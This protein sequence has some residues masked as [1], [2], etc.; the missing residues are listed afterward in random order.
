MAGT[1]LGKAWVQIVPS[2]DGISGS[3]K[4][5]LDPEAAAAGESAGSKISGALKKTMAAG[6]AAVGAATDATGALVKKSVE[7]FAEYEQLAGGVEKIFDQAN[8]SKIMAD[9]DSAYKDLNMSA[10]QYLTSINQTG[11]AFAQ[12]M[13]DQKGYDIART[14]MKAIA[15]YSSGTGRNLDELNEKYALITRS[16]SS[17][18]SIADQFSGILP[19]T[20]KD[21]LEQAKAAGILSD[22]YSSLT[23]VPIAEY[24]EAV[25]KM[26][27]KGVTDMGLYGNTAKEST[28]TISG[29]LAMTKSAWENLVAGFANPD[30]DVG[31]LVQQL[32]ESIMGS[33]DEAGNHVKGL[34]DNIVPAIMQAFSGLGTAMNTILPQMMSQIPAL[35]QNIG[36][37]LIQSGGQL[38]ASLA[39][40][41]MTALPQLVEVVTG[42][43]GTLADSIKNGFSTKLNKSL[44]IALVLS[45]KIREGAG[46]IVSSGMELLLNLAKG[47]AQSIPHIIETVPTIISNIAGVINDNAPKILATGVKIIVTLAKGLIQAIPTLIANIPKIIKAIWDVFTA[48]NWLNLGKTIITGIKNGITAL[49]DAVPRKLKE[50]GSKAVNA[51]KN[52][53]WGDV[54][55]RVVQGVVNGIKGIGSTLW[56]SLKTLG[57][58]AFD[59]FKSINW[60]ELGTNLVQGIING[61]MNMV[62]ALGSAVADLVKSA[63]RRG[64]NAA[65]SHSPSKLF[66]RGLGVPIGQGVA[67]GVRRSTPMV[68]DAVAD[69]INSANDASDIAVPSI[70]N[71]GMTTLG[72]RA[73]VGNDKN[74]GSTFN[75]YLDY[76]ATNDATDMVTEIARGV[77]QLKLTGAI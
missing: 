76:N 64:K 55:R 68:G 37:P 45:Q 51:L 14:G 77:R 50:L 73:S 47:I 33:T 1:E 52:I 29:S 18:Q 42:L 46:K 3:I 41:L 19:A 74:A 67:L 36:L 32:M 57:T 23:D 48:I 25:T 53:N 35:I 5:I 30:A 9:A 17:Y 38:V 66:M 6:V 27:E 39:Q 7:S 70:S 20:S 63:F 56:N 49:K 54:G 31:A 58:Q 69:M 40:G 2:A 11:A 44:D 13:G 71:A 43:L 15:D 28:E 22:S 24:Q 8:I 72:T 75:F 62:G 65:E 34:V 59:S 10:N 16:T 61:V 60:K 12:T 26:L 4:K 21:F